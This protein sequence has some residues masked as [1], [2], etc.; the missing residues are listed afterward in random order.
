MIAVIAATALTLGA[1]SSSKKASST[2]GGSGD[3][4][5][6]GVTATSILLGT[7]QPLTGPAAPGY[8]KISAAMSAYFAYA[9]AGGGV[10]GRKVT[11]KVLDDGY[12]PTT[13]ATDTRELVLQDK[14]FALVGALGT[15]THTAVL[16]FIK[17]NK[18]P[19][20]FVSSG[21]RSWNQPTKYPTT[22]GW[23]P[24][25]T[26]EGKILGD[27]VKKNFAGK[28]VCTFGQGDDF[29]TDGAQGVELTLGSGSLKTKQTYTPTNTNVG[30]QIGALKAAGCQVN[31]AFTVPG[32]TALA[33][34]TAAALKYQAQWVVSNVGSDIVT[35]TGF[36]KTATKPLLE[37]VVSDAY[38]PIPT[39]TSNSW[40]QL[41]QKVDAQY[42]NNAPFDGNV[43]YGMALAY[44]TLQA[45]KA[46]GKTLTRGS[47]VAAV[48]KGGFT[49]PGLTPF[50]FSATDHSGYSGTQ[51]VVIH[52][53]VAAPT[54]PVYTTDDG[55][56]ALSTVSTQPPSAPANGLP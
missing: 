35:L 21:S 11:L 22:F 50:R 12:N 37:G 4:S 15:P 7:T 55:S 26:I 54:G 6:P 9:N 33:L 56:G 44:T 17:Q 51:V 3:T 31:V 1:C 16:D 38:A 30:P 40:I 41:F 24:D 39:D 10:N 19:D 13:T 23:Q 29:G 53:G 32:F 49:G 47:L 45:L 18:V 14:V 48:E 25:Y 46:A 52:G 20:L 34:G 28:T 36:L 8:S 2:G 5:A 27:Y 42:D 43:L